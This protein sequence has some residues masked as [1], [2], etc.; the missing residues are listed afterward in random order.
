MCIRHVIIRCVTDVAATARGAL[1]P[2]QRG[3]LQILARG[4]VG[5]GHGRGR[6]AAPSYPELFSISH[7]SGTGSEGPGVVPAGD[8]RRVL[9]GQAVLG[10][11]CIDIAKLALSIKYKREVSIYEACHHICQVFGLGKYSYNKKQ[12]TAKRNNPIVKV[13]KNLTKK[14]KSVI[15]QSA[16]FQ[17][18]CDKFVKTDADY[19]LSFNINSKIQIFQF[20]F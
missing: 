14:N 13:N 17:I 20:F 8:R 2:S 5:R 3:Q 6:A 10:R 4:G 12:I 9:R 19:W 18:L 1:R 16:K 11:D 7:G 15:R